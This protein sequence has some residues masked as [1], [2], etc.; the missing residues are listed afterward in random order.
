M[1]NHIHSTLFWSVVT[2]TIVFSV[3]WG[4]VAVF[5]VAM[6]DQHENIYLYQVALFLVG[7]FLSA[8]AGYMMGK[9]FSH[10]TGNHVFVVLGALVSSVIGSVIMS[11][12]IPPFFAILIDALL[13]IWEVKF[14]SYMIIAEVL[15][16][17]TSFVLSCVAVILRRVLS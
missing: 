14:L 1:R 17:G 10:F 5:S 12:N 2:S 6:V 13:S 7:V 11:P 16:V 8:F 9:I 4:A 3:F 15:A